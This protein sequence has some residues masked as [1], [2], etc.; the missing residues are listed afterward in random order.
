MHLI[1]AQSLFVPALAEIFEELGLQPLNVSSGIDMHALLEEQPDLIFVDADF[2]GYEPLRSIGT[3][4]T[5]VP[6]GIICIYSSERDPLWV[7]ACSDAGAA[8]VFSKSAERSEILSGVRE[9]LRR[10]GHSP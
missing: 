7:E 4:R 2:V 8:V 6:N 5:L 3:L 9:A 1:E 10:Q